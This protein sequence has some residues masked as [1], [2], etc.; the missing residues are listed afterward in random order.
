MKLTKKMKEGRGEEDSGWD[1]DK[2][3]LDCFSSNWKGLDASTALHGKVRT[4]FQ[5]SPLPFQCCI[6]SFQFGL[7]SETHS[8]RDER[9]DGGARFHL[10][11]IP[12]HAD[13]RGGRAIFHYG[14]CFCIPADKNRKGAC[15]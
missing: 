15:S 8:E 9:S 10:L 4:L 7:D 5:L 6:N 11:A 12:V 3:I 14:A 1:D 13:D 2:Y